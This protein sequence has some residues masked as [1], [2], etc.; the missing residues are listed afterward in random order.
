MPSPTFLLYRRWPCGV[1][2]LGWVIAGLL[3]LW[4]WSWADESHESTHTSDTTAAQHP[5]GPPWRY[6]RMN[7][8][9]TIV[10]YADLECPYCK[11]YDPILRHWID[12]HPEVNLQWHHLPLAMHE[13]A[14]TRQARLAE[15]IGESHGHDAFWQAITWIYQHTRS[16]GQGLPP[17][18]EYHG[19]DPTVQACLA[20]ERPNTI[21][22]GQA[23]EARHGGVSATPTLRLIDHHSGQSLTLAGPAEGDALLS[24]L[25]LL[26]SNGTAPY[27]AQLHHQMPADVVGDMPR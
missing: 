15:C 16:D 9:F 4:L 3:V 5:A 26:V 19:Q 6:G 13:P 20:S 17:D 22:Q 8:R 24:A 10:E 12:Q 2:L 7:A 14:A 21:I 25:D 27:A 1:W 23:N 11:A 18:T